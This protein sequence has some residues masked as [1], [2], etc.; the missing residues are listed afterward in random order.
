MKHAITIIMTAH[1]DMENIPDDL[2]EYA[3]NVIESIKPEFTD[4]L[5]RVAR[6]NTDASIEVDI[7]WKGGNPE[8]LRER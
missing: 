6:D 5:A 3:K 4:R 2:H 7:N 1:I 8:R